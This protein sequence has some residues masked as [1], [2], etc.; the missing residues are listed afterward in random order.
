[1]DRAD[2]LHCPADNG[3]LALARHDCQHGLL[4]HSGRQELCPR[5]YG[6]KSVI[7]PAAHEA[8]TIYREE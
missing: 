1:M 6:I 7:M 5:V 2:Y 3:D 4:V 8:S